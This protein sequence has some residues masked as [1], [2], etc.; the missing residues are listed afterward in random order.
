MKFVVIYCV[1][2]LFFKTVQSFM[3]QRFNF[4]T[5]KKLLSTSKSLDSTLGTPSERPF[6]GHYVTK[7]G[8]TIKCEVNDVKNPDVETGKLIS[9]LDNYKGYIYYYYFV[10]F[11]RK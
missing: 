6:N 4:N 2:G 10:K 5:Q 9:L 11:C 1:L 3:I 7:E 8:V